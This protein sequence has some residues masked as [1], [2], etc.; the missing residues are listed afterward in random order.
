M[1]GH[2]KLQWV[3]FAVADHLSG[4]LVEI[5]GLLVGLYLSGSAGV[6]G[7]EWTRRNVRLVSG[8]LV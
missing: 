5:E 1:R 6:G 8:G 4:G 3:L 2:F 7:L